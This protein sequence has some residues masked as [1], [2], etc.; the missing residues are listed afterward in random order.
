MRIMFVLYTEELGGEGCIM[1]SFI[2]CTPCEVVGYQGRVT[3]WVRNVSCMGMKVIV[4]RILIGKRGGRSP[5]GR[6]VLI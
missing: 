6:P 2:I 3:E 4:N 5:F 1:W